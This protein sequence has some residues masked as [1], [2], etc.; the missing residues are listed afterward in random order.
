[1]SWYGD[2]LNSLWGNAKS[3]GKGALDLFTG[4]QNNQ[5]FGGFNIPNIANQTISGIG[6]LFGSSGNNSGYNGFT[7]TPMG[8]KVGSMGGVNVGGINAKG[9]PMSSAT[10]FE[11]SVLVMTNLCRSKVYDVVSGSSSIFNMA[12]VALS[13]VV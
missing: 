5:A 8:S 11:P 3:F 2:A 13:K 7:N 6:S 1:M 12:A 10:T 9:I 4:G